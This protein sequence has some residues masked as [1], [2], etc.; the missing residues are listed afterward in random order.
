MAPLLGE[1]SGSNLSDLVYGIRQKK[2][3]FLL[4]LQSVLHQTEY[5]DYVLPPENPQDLYEVREEDL[6]CLLTQLQEQTEY[7]KIVWNCGSFSQSAQQVMECCSKVFCI[8]KENA[9]GKYRKLEL[10][11]FLRKETR[12]RLW[13][14]VQYLCPQ[15]ASGGFVQGGSVL[16]QLQSGDFA[17]QVQELTQDI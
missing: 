5:F 1:K 3:Q 2:E 12:Q 17:R 10:E 14:K 16:S 11:E 7:Q 8:V 6:A 15:A 4:C 13:E 9:F